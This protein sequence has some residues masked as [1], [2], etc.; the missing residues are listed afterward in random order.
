MVLLPLKTHLLQCHGCSSHLA[1]HLVCHSNYSP[2]KHTPHAF[3][4]EAM[5][6]MLNCGVVAIP[7]MK[8]TGDG[9]TLSVL[10]VRIRK[11]VSVDV[12]SEGEKAPDEGRRL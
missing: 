3:K 6:L 7:F 10:S 2:L 9:A 12:K 1:A 8:R 4:R 11:E 5:C